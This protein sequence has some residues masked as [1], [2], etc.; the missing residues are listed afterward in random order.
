MN[1]KTI[2]PPLPVMTWEE[3]EQGRPGQVNLPEL[4]PVPTVAER[5]FLALARKW[6]DSVQCLAEGVERAFWHPLAHDDLVLS[7]LLLSV[8]WG[9]EFTEVA[10]KQM[11]LNRKTAAAHTYL[12]WTESLAWELCQCANGHGCPV[13]PYFEDNHAWDR[14]T[15]AR[16]ASGDRCPPAQ[17][18]A[19]ET[20]TLGLDYHTS[21]IRSWMMD[22]GWIARS[23]L[24]ALQAVPHLLKNL[25]DTLDAPFK[26]VG[27]AAALVQDRDVFWTLAKSFVPPPG[28]EE[29]YQDRLKYVEEHGILEMQSPFWRTEALCRKKIEQAGLGFRMAEGRKGVRK[30]TASQRKN[31]RSTP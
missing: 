18:Q 21:A 20:L 23:W 19:V 13:I 11:E 12:A 27:L 17:T 25:A 22:L 10:Q 1:E 7:C 28:F 8:E 15:L 4:T 9:S 29:Q 26:A 31:E 2:P 5:A 14:W 30:V 6:H 24:V 16:V 3:I